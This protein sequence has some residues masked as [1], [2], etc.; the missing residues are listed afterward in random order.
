MK[1]PLVN[2]L[3]FDESRLKLYSIP[4]EFDEAL[5]KGSKKG[6]VGATFGA[7][8][9]IQLFLAKYCDKYMAAGPTFK[10]DRLGFVSFSTSC[11]LKEKNKS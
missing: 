8:H 4:E 1:D 5:S 11:I 9:C 3:L 10:T 7:Q 6:G 2:K